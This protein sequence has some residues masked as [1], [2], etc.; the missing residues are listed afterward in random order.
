MIYFAENRKTSENSKAAFR[1]TGFSY[2]E[3]AAVRKLHQQI[4]GFQPTPLVSLSS[5]ARCAGVRAVLVKD[6]SSR[7]G[8]KAFK[9]LGG[10]YAMFRVICR[11]LQLDPE[12]TTFRMLQQEPHVSKIRQ[13]VF[14]TTTDG[15]HGKGI[16]WAARVFG[17][18]AFVYMPVGTVE[19]RAQA[20]R[21]AGNAELEI[22][23]M[24]YDECVTW[25]AAKAKE[26]GWHLVQDT[27]WSGYEEIPLWIM[28]GYT[29]MYYEASR[30]MKEM[31]YE[32]PTHIFLQ[33]GVGAMAGAVTAAAFSEAA[34]EVI[35]ET[36]NKVSDETANKAAGEQER[37]RPVIVTAESTEAAC[38]YDSFRIGSGQPETAHG[39]EKTIMAG[40]NCSVPC[41]L[42]W[43]I[44]G[45]CAFGGFAC[46]D[47]V[48]C[49]GMRLLAHPSGSDPAIISG[50]SGAVSA[51]LLKTLTQSEDYGDICRKLR[52]N[53]DSVVLLISTEGD[54]DPE[55]YRRIVG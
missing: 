28:Q 38:F 37:Q 35:G 3:T 44:L 48:T 53:Q 11:E 23:K 43:E 10:I 40:L 2:R 39:S 8:L 46:T 14:A 18:K 26:N 7:F 17:C 31:G 25:T 50:E 36:A 1:G 54:T 13:M 30:Q 12:Q 42:A 19:V 20:I 45:T 33:A 21:D 9:G 6:E 27:S 22:T 5:F 34:G 41:T 51:G 49:R 52:L 4:P 29:T 15:N 47:E 16:S 32:A 24:H 55:N